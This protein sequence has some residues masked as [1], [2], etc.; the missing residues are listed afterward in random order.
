[1]WLE[2]GLATLERTGADL[3][4]GR[5]DVPL[6]AR[7]SIAELIDV[8]G[9][10]DQEASIAENRSAVTANLFVRRRVFDA[11]G[12]FNPN[13]IS[14]GDRELCLRAAQA[15]FQIAYGPD[16]V[17]EHEP[18]TTSRELAKKAYRYGVG[19]AQLTAYGARAA[20]RGRIWSKPGAWL[21]KRGPLP[22]TRLKPHAYEPSRRE[23]AGMRL[24]DWVAQRLPMAAG[25]VVG[26]LRVARGGPAARATAEAPAAGARTTDGAPIAA[27]PTAVK[28][29][30]QG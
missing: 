24:V 11:V 1:M 25:N 19:R 3:V 10:F 14:G 26:S 8:G 9:S 13:T 28:S 4:G 23:L 29:E 18:R 5:I 22:V 20:D 7:P 6:R 17:I 30:S 21:P 2:N 27:E 16:A 15:G 12:P